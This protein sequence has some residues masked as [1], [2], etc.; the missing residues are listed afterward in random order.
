[1]IQLTECKSS[2]VAAHGYE[3]SSNTLAIRLNSGR[4]YHYINVPADVAA[5]FAAAESIGRAYG[6]LIKGKYM[7]VA[8]LDEPATESTH[9]E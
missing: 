2:A 6:S 5:E 8:V 1:M 4:V 3:P 9:A 7:H